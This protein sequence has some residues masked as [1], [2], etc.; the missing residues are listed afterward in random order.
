M[1]YKDF[2]NFKIKRTCNKK[3]EDYKKYKE[4]LAKDFNHRCAYC[5]TRDDII[6]PLY[7][8]IDHYVPRDSFKGKN[9]NLENDYNNLMYACPKCNFAKGKK[10]ERRYK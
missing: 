9:E 1:K 6:E 8:T 4:Y 7:F 10:Y 3:F 5:N 2:R